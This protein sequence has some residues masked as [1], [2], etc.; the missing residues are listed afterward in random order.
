MYPLTPLISKTMY[1]INTKLPFGKYKNSTIFEVLT[2]EPTYIKWCLENIEGFKL[3]P[4]VHEVYIISLN[5]DPN[6]NY[7]WDFLDMYDFMD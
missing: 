2:E 5:N 7:R 6:D 3:E 1:K 4:E